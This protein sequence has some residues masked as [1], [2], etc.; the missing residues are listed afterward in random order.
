MDDQSSLHRMDEQRTPGRNAH[1]SH[2]M[3]TKD[4]RDALKSE[5]PVTP[6]DGALHEIIKLDP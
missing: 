5:D 6:T 1:F 2:P 4:W 3:E